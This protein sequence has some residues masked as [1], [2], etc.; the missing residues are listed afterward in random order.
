MDL[1]ADDDDDESKLP[2]SAGATA[3]QISP[4]HLDKFCA[5]FDDLLAT[6][7]RVTDYCH[8]LSTDRQYVSPDHAD[9][10]RRQAQEL[11]QTIS[12]LQLSYGQALRDVRTGTKPPSILQDLHQ[13]VAARDG[14]LLGAG[15]VDQ[16]RE[17]IEFLARAAKNGAIHIGYNSKL[18]LT[19]L[20]GKNVRGGRPIYVLFLSQSAMHDDSWP[21]NRAL[22]MELLNTEHR[23]GA[24]VVV[25]D[26]D[27][28]G[29][30]LDAPRIAEFQNGAKVTADL[31]ER[32]RYL[33]DKCFAQCDDH[34]FEA[35]DVQKPVKRRFIKIP[36]PG[37]RCNALGPVSWICP[38][39]F[40]PL[41]Y[42]LSDQYV[43]CD[44]GR[45]H[46][47][48]FAFKCNNA[49]TH[50]PVYTAYSDEDRL[51][52]LLQNLPSCDYVNILILGETGVGKST[53]INA[54]INY[55]TFDTLDDALKSDDLQWVIPCS[56]QT[57]VMDRSRP[58]GKIIQHK[59]HVGS[60]DD[61]RDGI[62]GDSATQQ[63][64]VY[65][66]N[67]GSKTIRLIDTP[68][69]GDTRGVQ[70]DKKNMADILATLNSYEELH[71]IL[72]LLKS[73]NARLNLTFEFCLKELLTHL[74]RT[75]VSNIAFGFTNTRIS[76]YTPGDTFGPL[77]TLLAQQP[78]VQL[79]LTMQTSYCFDSESF[80]YLA[81]Y[82]QDVR[83]AARSTLLPSR[84]TY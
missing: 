13:S 27:A 26:C 9:E 60:R 18:S 61:E 55:L 42:G 72:I 54:F 81:A 58:D 20:L 6:Q 68:G 75:A 12:Q 80:R 53:F 48:N 1:I 24:Q 8:F 30:P 10:V 74:H 50:G 5:T 59:I 16:Q 64:S 79:P 3:I 63:T 38:R 78:D 14:H 44:C 2:L 28:T 33:A 25:E 4:E 45:S 35:H 71:G 57:Q 23:T 82:K 66:I 40:H 46:F 67:I 52:G 73:N 56:F 17:K 15:L 19:G 22:L 21:A 77:E 65:P 29:E 49:A 43:Y 70:F 83:W 41:E 36:C 11:Q 51:Q 69:I 32:R 47:R 84:R 7:R 31:L 37:P 34:A 76:N 62:G 39:C